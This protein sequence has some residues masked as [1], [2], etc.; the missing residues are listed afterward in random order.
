ML[1]ST[2]HIISIRSLS[3]G[4]KRTWSEVESDINV[5]INQTQEEILPGFDGNASFM[6][7]RMLTDGNHSAIS[8]DDR[9]VDENDIVYEVKGKSVSDDMTGIHHQYILLLKQE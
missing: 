5:Y 8:I 4:S 1:F 2:N 9:I 3:T 7:Y 6:V